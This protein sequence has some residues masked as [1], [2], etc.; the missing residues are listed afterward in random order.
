MFR[1]DIYPSEYWGNKFLKIGGQLFH[2]NKDKKT[3]QKPIPIDASP[4][5]AGVAI[6]FFGGLKNKEIASYRLTS[7][8]IGF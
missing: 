2:K 6:S 4:P 3:N 1:C 8:G 7:M 5:K